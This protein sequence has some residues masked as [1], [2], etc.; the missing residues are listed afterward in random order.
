M[1]NLMAG[2]ALAG[3]GIGVVFAFLSILICALYF[4]GKVMACINKYFP[5]AVVAD[6]GMKS[7]AASANKENEVAVAIL[8]ALIQSGTLRK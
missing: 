7:P 6:G 5:E 2:I 3:I 1:E 4:A 8:S